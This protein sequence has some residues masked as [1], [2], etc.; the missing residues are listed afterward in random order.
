MCGLPQPL[1]LPRLAIIYGPIL[2]PE[3][4]TA[5]AAEDSLRTEAVWTDVAA[6]TSSR[7][8]PDGRFLTF[9]DWSTGELWMRDVETEASRALTADGDWD[10]SGSYVE[11]ALIS[12]DGRKIA[13]GVDESRVGYLRV[14]SRSVSG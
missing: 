8:S 1:W 10:H 14:A 6:D 4:P 9:V 7:L 3:A 5:E 11:T 12:P 2:N 13:S